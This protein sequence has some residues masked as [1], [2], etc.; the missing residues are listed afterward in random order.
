MKRFLSLILTVVLL[1]SLVSTGLFSITASAASYV[2]TSYFWNDG[3]Y[4]RSEFWDYSNIGWGGVQK[5]YITDCEESKSGDFIIDYTDLSEIYVEGISSKAFYNCDNLLSITIPDCVDSISANAF[6]DCDNLIIYC[7]DAS[8]P[9]GWDSNWNSSNCPVVWDCYNNDVATDGYVYTTINNLR[10][11]VKDGIATVITQP[12]NSSGEIV[13]PSYVFYKNERYDVTSIAAKAFKDCSN[14]TG[15]TIPDSVENIGSY[16]FSGCSSITFLEIPAGFTSINDNTFLGCS[17]ITDII[18]PH[19]VES[20]G[21]AAFDNCT[22]ITDIWYEGSEIQKNNITIGDNNTFLINATWHYD[23]CIKSNKQHT[24]SYVDCDDLSC[25][26]CGFTR[27]FSGH[28]YDNCFDTTCNNCDFVRNEGHA[29]QNHADAECDICGNIRVPSEHTYSSELDISCDECGE[30][31]NVA[32][33]YAII[34]HLDGGI[35]AVKNP[36]SYMTEDSITLKD[37]AKE[38]YTFEG[39]YSD[40]AKTQKITTISNRTGNINVYAKF[41]ANTYTATFN[42]NGA[43]K[44]GKIK[45]NIFQQVLLFL[46]VF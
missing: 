13:I 7:E 5:L 8:K 34:Y 25:N 10:Y 40:Q 6:L 19:N 32:G 45:Q 37:A 36:D 16:A 43:D 38:G 39:W 42:G 9:S 22:G 29:Y 20:I 31:R 23:A 15:I 21:S 41:T 12:Q 14:V 2:S 27:V 44:L 28:T 3:I 35:N 17:N 33:V 18:I 26:Y 46:L 4:Y 11:K 30:L 24:H 1:L